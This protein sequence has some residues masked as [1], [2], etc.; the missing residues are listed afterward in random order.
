MTKFYLSE[1][2]VWHDST[3][4]WMWT[5]IQDKH[6]YQSSDSLLVDE[7]KFSK[8]NVPQMVSN[9]FLSSDNFILATG[10]DCIFKINL[11]SNRIDKQITLPHSNLFRCNDGTVGPDGK[12]WFGTM[13][14]SPTGLNG[15][16]YSLD[17]SMKLV[18]QNAPIG[19]P[20]SF[21]WLDDSSIL[22]SDSLLQKTYKVSLAANGKLDWVNRT[23]WLDLSDTDCTPDG[24]AIDEKGNIWLA[25][26]GGAAIHKYSAGG[27]LLD[28]IQLKAL[29][30][31]SCAFG[32]A[33]MDCL[34]ITTATEGLSGEHLVQYPDSGEVLMH[35]LSVKGKSLPKFRMTA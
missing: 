16:V 4:K 30:P 9:L 14:K 23:I 12:Y 33:N 6:I 28:K 1:S 5:D 8:K 13:E 27:E 29:Q 21:I 7:N 34:L 26:W 11:S 17:E 15:E 2:P 10:E 25:I 19:I 18:A 20:N 31:T 22:I 3:N 24:G 35:R 32:G